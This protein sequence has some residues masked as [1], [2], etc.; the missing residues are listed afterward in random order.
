[1]PYIIHHPSWRPRLEEAYKAAHATEEMAKA[2]TASSPLYSSVDMMVATFA[3]VDVP[4]LGF[5]D[6]HILYADIDILF[7]AP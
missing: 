2:I 7:G 5:I 4:Q 3:R 1:M 6:E